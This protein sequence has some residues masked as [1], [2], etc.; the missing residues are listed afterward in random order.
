[1]TYKTNSL[2]LAGY[3]LYKNFD[4]KKINVYEINHTDFLYNDSPE[5][6]KHVRVFMSGKAVV[7]PQRY[8]YSRMSLKRQIKHRQAQLFYKARNTVRTINRLPSIGDK[9]YCILDN[10]VLAQVFG[11]GDIHRERY[12]S[13]NYYEAKNHAIKA[14]LNYAN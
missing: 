13:G 7:N 14:L 5:L 6:Q 10:K 9:Y 11:V 3:L 1:M 2:D 8:M 4:P 12:E